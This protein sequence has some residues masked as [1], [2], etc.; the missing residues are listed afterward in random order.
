MRLYFLCYPRLHRQRVVLNASALPDPRDVNYD[1]LLSRV[2]SYLNLYGLSHLYFWVLKLIFRSRSRLYRNLLCRW[3][4][5][6]TWLELGMEGLSW[7]EQKLSEELEETGVYLA[8]CPFLR[9]LT[10]LSS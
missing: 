4:T 3:R 1:L 9:L 2:L 8:F 7:A 6:H 5:Q 10:F